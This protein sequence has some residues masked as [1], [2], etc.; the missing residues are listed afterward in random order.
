MRVLCLCLVF[1]IAIVIAACAG[2]ESVS[3]SEPPTQ[4]Q[5]VSQPLAPQAVQRQSSQ[6][7]AAASVDLDTTSVRQTEAAADRREEMAPTEVSSEAADTPEAQ[8]QSSDAVSEPLA[9]QATQDQSRTQTSA[10]SE[11]V[12]RS[13]D[14]GTEPAAKDERE[15]PELLEASEEAEVVQA[16]ER[17]SADTAVDTEE[18]EAREQTAEHSESPQDLTEKLGTVMENADVRVRPGLAWPV[19]DRLESGVSVEVLQQAG[20]WYRIRFGEELQGW[21]RAA[22]LHLGEAVK[23]Q[24][25]N[26]PAAP[27]VAEWRGSDYGVI[28]QSADGA[29]VRLLEMSEESPWLIGAP[30]DEVTMLADDV[31]LE[32]LP[33]VI[34]D[35][36]VVFPG[37]DFR[38]GQ[39]KILPKAN[40]WM[41]LPRGWL[42]A[43]NDTH[44][45]QW[46]PET[47]ELEFVEL[48]PGFARQSPDG[49]YLAIAELCTHDVA[50]SQD[51]R[52]VI[53]PLDG[54]QRFT[55]AEEF[56]T[57]EVAS[58]LGRTS[59]GWT[60]NLTWSRN[61]EAVLLLVAL[62]DQGREPSSLTTLLF[63]IEGHMTR[64]DPYWQ[65][66]IQGRDCRVD[67]PFG[68]GGSFGWWEFHGDDTIAIDAFCTDI[69]GDLELYTLVFT[70]AGDFLRFEPF[71]YGLSREE[72]VALLRSA[73]G[74]DAVGEQISFR[75][76]PLRRHALV[77]ERS[78]GRT[79]LY[80]AEQHDLRAVLVQSGQP[81]TDTRAWAP[82]DPNADHEWY[83][84]DAYWLK[85][86]Q[87]LL[88]AAWHGYVRD[89]IYGAVL[90]NLST[91]QGVELDFGNKPW[92]HWQAAPGW[93]PTGDSFQIMLRGEDVLPELLVDGLYSYR[94]LIV[95]RSGNVHREIMTATSCHLPGP[96]PD[97][98]MHRADWSPD[99][100]LFAVGGRALGG[101]FPCPE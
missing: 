48:P 36:T 29:E 75:W 58:S 25:P 61:S 44:I 20:G 74:G 80:R 70:F 50:C 16:S 27:L 96:Y 84:V 73:E 33:I 9:Q 67:P 15:D 26:A 95:G 69:N 12:D 99:G 30:I 56:K 34:G 3:V 39:G 24:V 5:Q 93:N 21:V 78:T 47:D 13:R 2:D 97:V 60:A 45:W 37:D 94:L 41:W 19:I 10:S 64:F 90:L 18:D 53:I 62:F 52:V 6:Q 100:K 4:P 49:R 22:M 81:P 42:L 85:E 55:F 28:G 65:R 63:H 72:D 43:H 77:F 40:E 86:E 1:L 88:L 91:A 68:P 76:S 35:E 11:A 66:T 92:I 89:I 23:R 57:L 17:Q 51:N 71:G 79:F 98:P 7:A 101:S 54:S 59:S 83:S 38:A 14:A 32:D 46:R 8:T 87:A 82:F 31:M